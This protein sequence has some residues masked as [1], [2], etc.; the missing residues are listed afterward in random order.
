MKQM[1][2]F[3]TQY[4]QELLYQEIAANK[5]TLKGFIWFLLAVA[6]VWV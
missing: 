2:D 6:L 5:N 4:E 1:D 3:K